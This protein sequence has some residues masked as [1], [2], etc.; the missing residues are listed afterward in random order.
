ML[1]F[2]SLLWRLRRAMTMETGLFE[3]QAEQLTE[4]RM[5]RQVNADSR[6]IVYAVIGQP[7]SLNDDSDSSSS[8]ITS[9]T[10]TPPD[11]VASAGLTGHP[12]IDLARCFF[13][14]RQS[15]QLRARSS[16]PI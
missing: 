4:V 11:G 7:H 8:V 14:A 13:A 10:E 2:A 6:Q 1:R 9:E 5:P 16:Q 15:A 12:T 3:I